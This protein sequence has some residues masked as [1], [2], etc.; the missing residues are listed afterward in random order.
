MMYPSLN[1]HLAGFWGGSIIGIE[2]GCGGL[3]SAVVASKSVG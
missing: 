3:Q 2:F 1:Q